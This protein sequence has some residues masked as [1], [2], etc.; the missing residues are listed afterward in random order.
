M[1]GYILGLGDRH[2]FNIL[3]DMS[4]AELIHIDLGLAFDQVRVSCGLLVIKLM[5]CWVV[6]I[7]L[8]ETHS[9]SPHSTLMFIQAKLL[10]IPETIPFR[11]TQDI[12]DGCVCVCPASVSSGF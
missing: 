4:T 10:K 12:V 3:I 9:C 8:P 11:L 6:L 7:V 2:P 1:V 5:L